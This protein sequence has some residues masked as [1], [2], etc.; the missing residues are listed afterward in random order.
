MI[1]DRLLQRIEPEPNTGC[2]LWAGT[3]GDDGYGRLAVSWKKKARAHRAVWEEAVGPIPDGLQ[4]DH[5]C[6]V[7]SCVNPDH[8]E[9]VTSRE[10]TMRGNHPSAVAVRTGK[11]KRGHERV[12]PH[13]Y[14]DT[15]GSLRC[16]TCQNMLARER[17][18][19]RRTVEGA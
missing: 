1:S 11:C 5:L 19:R 10:N 16:R 14:V 8:L 6:R 15:R 13:T 17:W 12:R 18:A 3:L 9:V 2:W 7:R 4:L